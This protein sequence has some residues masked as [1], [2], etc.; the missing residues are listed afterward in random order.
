MDVLK[1]QQ[2]ISHYQARARS[3][4]EFVC[5]EHHLSGLLEMVW[6]SWAQTP[7]SRV[8]GSALRSRL[9]PSLNHPGLVQ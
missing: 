1:N 6:K 7:Y 2:R 4:S 5:T 8:N 3:K 9:V